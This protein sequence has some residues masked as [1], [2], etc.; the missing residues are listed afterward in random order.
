[1]NMARESA[2]IRAEYGVPGGVVG[3]MLGY[4]ARLKRQAEKLI[5]LGKCDLIP[6]G[7]H[8]RKHMRDKTEFS[9]N[10]GLDKL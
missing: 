6:G 4:Y 9:S 10:I 2:R 3:K 1:M 7:W 5:V 8:L